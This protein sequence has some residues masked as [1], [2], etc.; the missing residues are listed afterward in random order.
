[1]MTACVE[2][3]IGVGAPC[4]GLLVRRLR[5]LECC[6]NVDDGA[7][8]YV[9]V[10]VRVTSN[11]HELHARSNKVMSPW[12]RVLIGPTVVAF[13][14]GHRFPNWYFSIFR[15]LVPIVRVGEQ[16]RAQHVLES[17]T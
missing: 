2:R 16:L 13:L 17:S 6:K 11:V 9:H 10:L 12:H 4:L 5:F 15:A 8:F 7:P 3:T 1:M 14:L